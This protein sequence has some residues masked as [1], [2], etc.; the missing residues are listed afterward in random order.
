MKAYK[1]GNFSGNNRDI[2]PNLMKVI[3]QIE[4]QEG[5]KVIPNESEEKYSA[6]LLNLIKPYNSAFAEIDELENLLDLAAIAWNLANMK[7]LSPQAYSEMWQEAKK[8]FVEDKESLKI[9]EKLIKQKT[10][11][12]EQYEMFIHQADVNITPEG[13]IFVTATAKPIDSF[14]QDTVLNEEE[15]DEL[16]YLPGFVNRNALTVIPKKPF[17]D[18]VKKVEGNSLFP[19][20]AIENN[21]YL[22]Q[23]KGSNEEIQEW[24]NKNFER[25]FKKEL[26]AWHTLEKLWPENRT[27]QMFCDWFD[28]SYQS[29]VYDMED[30]PVD[31]DM[32]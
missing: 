10:K 12:Y 16:N 27:Y 26:E 19:L 11:M 15:E 18:W 7:K 17:L 1:G 30:Y 23:E 14:L 2:D 9:L 21:I 5:R 4:K 25:V 20:E 13:E 22:V 29:M 32:Q 8:D 24:L 31:K 6:M 28:V 3:K